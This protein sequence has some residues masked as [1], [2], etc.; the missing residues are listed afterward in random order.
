[1]RAKK[2]GLWFYT[3][4]NGY[5]IR[6]QIVERLRAAGLEVVY[7]FDMRRCYCLDGEVYTADHVNLSSMDV[8]FYMNAEERNPHQHDMLRMLEKC[9]VA[10][11]NSVG[12]YTAANDKFVANCTL[13]RA[14]VNVARSMLI[15]IEL[16]VAFARGIVEE[17]KSVVVKPRDKT[18]ATGIMKFDEFEP[19]YDFC[20]FAQDFVGNL[21]IER[22]IPFRERDIRVEVFDGTVVGEGFSRIMGHSFKTNVRSGGRA[23]FIP[24]EEDARQMALRAAKALGMT[25][26]IVDLVRSLEDGEPYVL[27][28]NPLLGVFYGAHFASVGQA[29]PPYFARMDELKIDL[30]THHI[31]AMAEKARGREVPGRGD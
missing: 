4:E 14:G 21:Y 26:T 12:S 13:R 9:G 27:E 2:V 3:N 31:I 8:F 22:Y 29:V 5:L 6:E 18:C 15:P 11:L 1:M 7:D 28:V 19:F 24:A 17:W 20:L 16:D 30:I 10:M 23:T 25:A